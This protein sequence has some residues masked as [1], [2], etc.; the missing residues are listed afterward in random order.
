MR[1]NGETIQTVYNDKALELYKLLGAVKIT[2]YSHVEYCNRAG[3][4]VA[5]RP[6]GEILCKAATREDCLAQEKTI[7][8][9]EINKC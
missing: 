3:V 9:K 5:R 6:S 1:L 8:E 2:R 7:A 4:W